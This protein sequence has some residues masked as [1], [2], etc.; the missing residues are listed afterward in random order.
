MTTQENCIHV[1]GFGILSLSFLILWTSYFDMIRMK[2]P[3]VCHSRF[4]HMLLN[5]V[6]Y[7]VSGLCNNVFNQFVY[8]VSD[9]SIDS[10][11]S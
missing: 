9:N 3:S 2:T 5:W 10:V 11:L 8:V 6:F 7:R 1:W 4:F